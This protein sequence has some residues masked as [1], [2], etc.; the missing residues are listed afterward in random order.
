MNIKDIGGLMKQAQALQEKMAS[1][2]QEAAE[3]VVTGEAGAGLCRVEM[4]GR[5]EVRAVFIDPSL[6]KED[7]AIVEDLV[8]A[9]FNAAV[10]QVATTTQERMQEMAKKLG[11]PAG[12][13]LGKMT[14]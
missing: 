10:R 5:H 11:L 2:Q 9:A 4:N 8:A 14:F 1:M 7:K 3:L 12:L 13:P 6:M